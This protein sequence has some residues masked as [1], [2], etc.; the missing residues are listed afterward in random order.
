MDLEGL[1]PTGWDD[2]TRRSF[3]G[4]GALV[5]GSVAL[6][7]GCGGASH[8]L[9]PTGT[10]ALTTKEMATLE[11]VL[12]QLLPK[13]GLGP[14]AV[15]AGVPSYINNAL[16]GSYKPLLPV[17]QSLLPMFE[18]AAA[19]M[20]ASSFS[21]LSAAQQTALLRQ[22]EAGKPPG[23]A[24]A[25]AA[26]AASGFQ[27]LLEHMREGMFGDPMYGGNANLAGWALIGYPDIHLAPAA[28]EQAVDVKVEPSRES[29][30][31]LGGSPYNGPPV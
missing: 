3:L 12:A 1:P 13:D 14:G 26:S 23:V 17:Y 16:A 7:A 29:A 21:A 30:K 15:E 4:R 10:G 11:S 8:V 25:A 24:A 22:F 18:K 28:H 19:S 27:V 31:T 9:K 20:G 2:I 5:A 6:L